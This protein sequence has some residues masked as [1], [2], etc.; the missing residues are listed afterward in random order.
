[1]SARDI[2]IFF[3]ATA[4]SLGAVY[5]A[6]LDLEKTK[7]KEAFEWADVKK[8]SDQEAIIAVLKTRNGDC[9][10]FKADVERKCK[11]VRQVLRPGNSV[12]MHLMPIIF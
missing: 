6:V 11:L 2:A 8:E 3:G 1:M 4:V 5:V 10:I 9:S 12:P 7:L